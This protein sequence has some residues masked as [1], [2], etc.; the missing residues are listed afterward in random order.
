M[1]GNLI[2]GDGTFD[3]T[4]TSYNITLA[5]NWSNTF[6]TFSA[7]LGTVTFDSTSTGKTIA[8]NGYDWYNVTFDGL[9][10]GWSF[11]DSTVISNDLVVTTGTLSGTND[12]TVDGGDVTG[13]GTITLTGG[14]FL[15]DGAGSFGGNTNWTFN[16]LTF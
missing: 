12:V 14:T 11:S 9:G 6:A 5:G 2:L 4:A 3:V 15:L 7:R 8:D 16:N 13:N 1:D 10:G